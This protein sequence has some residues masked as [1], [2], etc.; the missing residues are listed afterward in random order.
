MG[1]FFF[2]SKK[3]YFI[4]APRWAVICFDKSSGLLTSA[5]LVVN[6]LVSNYAIS[7]SHQ[8][9]LA[10]LPAVHL[11]LAT[12]VRAIIVHHVLALLVDKLHL[13]R[14]LWILLLLLRLQQIE[15]LI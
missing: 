9:G 4:F 8:L 10:I 12:A 2:S 1:R 7:L 3:Q 13:G 15:I 11:L 5:I 6:S 14:L